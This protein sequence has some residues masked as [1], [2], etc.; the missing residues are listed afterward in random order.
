MVTGDL[1]KMRGILGGDGR[2]RYQLP[3]GEDE[4]ELAPLLG[5][6]ISL[7][8]RGVIH[9]TACGRITR[10]SYSQ[11]Y[12]YPCAQRLAR[13]DLCIVKPETCHYD[14]GTCREPEWGEAN[15]MQPHF[16]YLSNTSGLKV[17]ITRTSQI[18]TRWIDQGATQALPILRVQTRYQA[19][20][21][22]VAFKAHVADRT[23][24]RMMLKGDNTTLNLHARRDALFTACT[25]ELA[26][27]RSRFGV[28]AFEMLPEAEEVVI[29]YPVRA[30]PSRIT[31]LNLDKEPQV[32]S[33]LQGIKGQYLMLDSGVLNIRKYTGYEISF[34]TE[35]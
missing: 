16:V 30:W 14:A 27:L 28:A 15:C 6:S 29:N 24:W 23:D 32:H 35:Q 26:A 7:H 17:G 34:S 4:V 12:C 1:D 2:V 10:K 9:C 18:P 19:G 20:L 25:D 5:R 13:C 22:E 33:L 21:V 11:G 31:A 3:L 8:A